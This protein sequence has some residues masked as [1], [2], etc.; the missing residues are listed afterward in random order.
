[1]RVAL[2]KHDDVTRDQRDT[3]MVLSDAGVATAFE[4]QMENNHMDGSRRQVVGHGAGVRFTHA[5][6]GGEFSIEKHRAVEFD[7]LQYLGEDIHCGSTN[8]ATRIG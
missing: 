2:W 6:G 4:D 7:G 8:Q 3:T 5:P 1:M